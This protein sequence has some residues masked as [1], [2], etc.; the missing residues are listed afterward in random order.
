MDVLI[1]FVL[2]ALLF[3][4]LQW[5]WNR[6]SWLRLPDAVR[7]VSS[8]TAT[9]T[10]APVHDPFALPFVR[11]RLG[12]IAAELEQLDSDPGIFAKAFRMQVAR[13]AYEA[14]LADATRL[15]A[16]AAMEMEYTVSA[17]PLREELDV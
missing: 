14:L 10:R 16:L 1:P 9:A 13:Y 3:V 15:T 4:V 17:G 11:N 6:P 7:G 2:P 12:V 8:V 5:C